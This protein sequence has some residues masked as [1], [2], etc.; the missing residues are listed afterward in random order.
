MFLTFLVLIGLG[1]NR[2]F[3]LRQF[4][5]RLVFSDVQPV[6]TLRLILEKKLPSE[7]SDLF[8]DEKALQLWSSRV[9]SVAQGDYRIAQALVL[10][11]IDAAEKKTKPL[12]M[13]EMDVIFKRYGT[14]PV[15]KTSIC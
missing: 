9:A 10:H 13:K 15:S 12:T 8:F 7:L 2:N 11:F 4:Q 5:E 14:L 6:E 1:N 3:G